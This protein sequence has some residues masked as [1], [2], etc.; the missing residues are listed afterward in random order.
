MTIQDKKPPAQHELPGI[1]KE[2][3][4]EKQ[5]LQQPEGETMPKVEVELANP[6]PEQEQERE[7]HDQ[8][9]ADD[10]IL[11]PHERDETTR[12]HA[13]SLGNENELSQAVIEQALEDTEHGLKDTDLRGIPSDIIES[14]IPGSDA[15]EKIREKK[16]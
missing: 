16:R 3:Q 11:L 9:Q 8:D 2:E 13:T 4:T 15:A 12:H 6:E 7:A 14:D 10:Q 1:E 5:F